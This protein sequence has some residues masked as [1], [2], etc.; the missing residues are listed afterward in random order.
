[1]LAASAW[2]NPSFNAGSF[3][4]TWNGTDNRIGRVAALLN[5]L[6]LFLDETK[7][8]RMQNK[9]S[10]F[11]SDLVTDTIYMTRTANDTTS[12]LDVVILGKPEP[13]RLSRRSRKLWKTGSRFLI[14]RL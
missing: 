12:P 2:G 14:R 5:G 13:K 1:M 11:G 6:P 9:K 4:N 8:A 10:K 7:L 3:L